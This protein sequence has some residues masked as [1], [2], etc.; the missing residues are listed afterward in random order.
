MKEPPVIWQGARLQMLINGKDLNVDLSDMQFKTIARI[1][2]F[3]FRYRDDLGQT[4]VSMYDDY[5]LDQF[6]TMRGNPLRL[7]MEQKADE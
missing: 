5:T 3:E 2:G 4:E 6:L 7:V 1:L